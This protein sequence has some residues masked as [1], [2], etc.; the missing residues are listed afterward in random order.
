MTARGIACI[1]ALEQRKPPERR[2]CDDPLAR[3]MVGPLMYLLSAIFLP[4]G[5]W[6]APGVSGFILAR[7]RYIDDCLRAGL[8]EGIRQVVILGAGLD[9][10]A[11]R[12]ATDARFFEVDHPA[13]QRAKVE[14]LRRV[15]GRLLETVRYVPL[16]FE[17]DSLDKLLGAGYDPAAPALFLWEGVTYYLRAAA[18]DATLAFVARRAARGS[19]IVFDYAFAEALT[20]R[21]LR[22]ELRRVARAARWTGEAIVFGI[23]EGTAAAFL[24]ARGFGQVEEVT[25]HDLEQMYGVQH[26]LPV[27]ALVRA[28]VGR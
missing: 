16:D 27:C 7:T 1:R 14:R 4:Y 21:P 18:V 13:T 26:V 11:Y 3:R 8:A 12:F 9:T 17:H 6:V 10:R 2:I 23:A 5:D 19:S 25:A 22:P 28:V 15:L 24:R 20:A